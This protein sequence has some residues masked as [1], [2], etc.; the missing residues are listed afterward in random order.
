MCPCHTVCGAGPGGG[1]PPN[2]APRPEAQQCAAGRECA[3]ALPQLTRLNRRAVL[4]T[5]PSAQRQPL[6]LVLAL[7][8]SPAGWLVA[9]SQIWPRRVL[10]ALAVFRQ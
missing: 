5:H 8:T 10:T 3:P 6:M 9:P 7:C 4:V 1:G 2:S